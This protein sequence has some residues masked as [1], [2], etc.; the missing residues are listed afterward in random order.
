[1]N[2]I[3]I[4]GD[5]AIG[6]TEPL[7]IYRNLHKKGRWYSVKQKGFVV[8]HTQQLVLKD[9]TFVVNKKGKERAQ[10]AKQRNVHAYL[11]GIVHQHPYI[12]V[13]PHFPLVTY[14]PFSELGFHIKGTNDEIKFAEMVIINPHGVFLK[15]RIE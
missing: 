15:G 1:M 6:Y 4:R 14:N 11:K 8:G 2:K 13:Q 5:Y 3:K 10:L 12:E 7:I 9:V